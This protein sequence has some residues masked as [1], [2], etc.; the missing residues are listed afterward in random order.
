MLEAI[1]LLLRELPEVPKLFKRVW[2]LTPA[3]VVD[4]PMLEPELP[5]KPLP[6]PLEPLDP[7]PVP[8]PKPPTCAVAESASTSQLM[9]A[10]R[11]E[12]VPCPRQGRAVIAWLSY[13]IPTWRVNRL[14]A[15]FS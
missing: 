8:P 1:A 13:R 7:P 2:E 3:V 15:E 5:P 4:V 9:R 14:T 11:I 10:N 6:E 12:L